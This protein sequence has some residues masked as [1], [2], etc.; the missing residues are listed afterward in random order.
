[1]EF[2]AQVL[3]RNNGPI[4]VARGSGPEEVQ[5]AIPFDSSRL[6]VGRGT[7]SCC[8]FGHMVNGRAIE[9]DKAKCKRVMRTMIQTR[10]Q[11]NKAAGDL[12]GYR[13][14]RAMRAC[15]LANLPLEDSAEGGV[16]ADMEA[17]GG[18][19]PSDVATFAKAYLFPP[20]TAAEAIEVGVGTGWSPLRFA[21]M[22][23]NV[24]VVR[25]LIEAIKAH[26][27]RKTATKFLECPLTKDN[28]DIFR[29]KGQTV[30]HEAMISS[31]AAVAELLLEA[32]ANPMHLA[33]GKDGM[34]ILDP[35]CSAALHTRPDMMTWWLD[36]FPDWDTTQ[37]YGMLKFG[38]LFYAAHYG[39]KEATDV[40]LARPA[41]S[42]GGSR[43]VK[44]PD[45]FCAITHE[46]TDPAT[47]Q[48][49]IDH[50]FKAN[51]GFNFCL[52]WNCCVGCI[53]N[54][55]CLPQCYCRQKCCKP[56]CGYK[57]SPTNPCWATMNWPGFCCSAKNMLFLTSPV[58]NISGARTLIDA[59][60]DERQRNTLGLDQ[61]QVARRSGQHIYAR[62]FEGFRA[63][64][65]DHGELLAL[66]AQDKTVRGP[67]RAPP[68]IEN[69]SRSEE[70][71]TTV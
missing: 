9:C 66:A 7:F 3:S 40:L 28:N 13:Y 59:G 52:D 31:N 63:G 27:N 8:T 36:K 71:I 10:L 48:M 12:Q 20:M 56:C 6:A 68:T 11:V 24:L 29:T 15:Y 18:V 42:K 33:K 35:L 4:L 32:G 14:L 39:G 65:R 23:R 53:A 38:A 62:Y 37:G 60:A 57:E 47:I 50:G 43:K 17:S 41:R 16:D 19:D 58:G 45:M 5:F 64:G 1:M 54:C 49:M 46:E 51:S 34:T 25:E 55:C 22:S 21:V 61:I 44:W 26:P 69:M 70:N 30:L 2:I 67:G